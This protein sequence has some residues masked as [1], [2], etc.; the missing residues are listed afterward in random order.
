[1]IDQ[2]GI[3]NSAAAK[4]SKLFISSLERDLNIRT[5]VVG[6]SGEL[7][8]HSVGPSAVKP[9]DKEHGNKGP[10]DWG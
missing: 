9:V 2:T 10:R 1:M 3:H 7:P 6:G 4:I 8:E 5:R